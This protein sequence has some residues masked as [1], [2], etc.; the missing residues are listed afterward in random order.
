M[1]RIGVKASITLERLNEISEQPQPEV[2]VVTPTGAPPF[3]CGTFLFTHLED[4]RAHC[5]KRK[6]S[7]RGC[8]CVFVKPPAPAPAETQSGI[9]FGP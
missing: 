8:H 5:A 6:H 3:R 2:E 1:R 7:Y 4:W 9:S